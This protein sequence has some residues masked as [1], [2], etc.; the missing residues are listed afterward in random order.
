MME[1]AAFGASV[2]F[3][4]HT[5]NF[6]ET[7][8]QLLARGGARRVAD[9]RGADG[10]PDGRPGRSR[11]R[12][13]AGGGGT[14][15]RAR[16]ARRVGPDPGRTRSPRRGGSTRPAGGSPRA[17]SLRNRRLSPDRRC[18]C[19]SP[20]VRSAIRIRHESRASSQEKP[21][22]E[23]EGEGELNRRGRTRSNP[24]D[25]PRS[26]STTRACSRRTRTSAG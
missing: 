22:S 17:G 23:R 8:E 16:A 11:G 18:V 15:L 26:T 20:V 14:R 9:A 24:A 3:G 5:A 7:V 1:P 6:R 10:R 19:P 2:L 13:G 12:R 4:P 25:R 21:M